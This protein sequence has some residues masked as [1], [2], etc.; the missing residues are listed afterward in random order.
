MCGQNEGQ[1]IQ[2]TVKD[3]TVQ[4]LRRVEALLKEK[5][6]DLTDGTSTSGRA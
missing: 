6:L 1:F 3:R 4:A 2:G 5:G